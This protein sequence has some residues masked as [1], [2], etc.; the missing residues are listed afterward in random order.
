MSTMKLVVVLLAMA[1]V[2]LAKFG[3]GFCPEVQVKQNFDAS[4]FLG[5]WFERVR[6]VNTPHENGVCGRTHYEI[7]SEGDFLVTNAEVVDGKWTK[8]NA[9][10]YCEE[11]EGTC[12]ISFF[13]SPYATLDI[14]DTDYENIAVT[15]SCWGLGLF[16]WSYGWV[17]AR[18]Q[19]PIDFQHAFEVL[20]KAYIPSH[21]L[22][23]VPQ[24]DCPPYQE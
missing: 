20:E 11:T 16:H 3:W 6:V 22:T 1:R 24:K 2:S 17:L 21:Y 4:K 8:V 5:S 10:G 18:T 12:Y 19:D 14:L 7:N 15:Y 23:Q 13:N 9:R